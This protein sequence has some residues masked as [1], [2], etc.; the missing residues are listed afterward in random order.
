M[1]ALF[2]SDSDRT[3]HFH[4]E[5][6]DFLLDYSKNIIDQ[7]TMDLLLELAQEVH[8]E[9]AITKYF[10]GEIIN[11][12]EN[13]A[14]LHTALRA[15]LKAQIIADGKNVMPEIFE[16]KNKMETFTTSVKGL[17]V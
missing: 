10:A 2:Q 9:E 3:T 17:P 16:V 12:T 7:Q 4:L 11:Q 14:V 6:N 13:R 5:W 15:P 1:K 8:L